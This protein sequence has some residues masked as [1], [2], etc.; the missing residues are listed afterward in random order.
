MTRITRLAGLTIALSALVP[1]L[2]HAATIAAMKGHH[3]VILIS[4]PAGDALL[5]EQRSLLE[6][7]H[8][9]ADERDIAVVEVDGTRVTGSDDGAARLRR[10]YALPAHSFGVLLIGKDGHVALRDT[11][12]LSGDRLARIIDAMPMRR[13]GQR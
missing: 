13:A 2:A 7:W 10:R 3:R 5:A 9:G 11:R 6:A 1:S 4:A 8:Q 12:P